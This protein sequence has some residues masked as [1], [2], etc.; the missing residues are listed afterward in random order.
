MPSRSNWQHVLALVKS[1]RDLRPYR[2]VLLD[3]DAVHKLIDMTNA[4][5]TQA[6]WD[7][8][9]RAEWLL[10]E[11]HKLD[12]GIDLTW[13]HDVVAELRKALELAGPTEQAES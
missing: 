5:R 7:F 3:P 13:D 8:V 10:Q 11:I 12:L 1:N 4:G 6:A 9:N 2:R